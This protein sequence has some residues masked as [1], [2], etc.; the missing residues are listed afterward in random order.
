MRSRLEADY[1]AWL[2]EAG[3]TWKYEPECFANESGQWLPD[4][5]CGAG[6][7]GRFVSFMEVKPAGPLKQLRAGSPEFVEHVDET[8][9]QMEIAWDSRPDALLALYFWEYGAASY[10]TL[11]ASRR[12]HPWY[13]ERDPDG[14]ALLW[15]GMGQ[16][17]RVRFPC[18][19]PTLHG[20]GQ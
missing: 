12:E 10:L 14:L 2:D 17:Q 7:S 4:F 18:P 9:R 8:L 15:P 6:K 5:G 3:M 13:V 19:D 20:D 16:F 11:F 1:A